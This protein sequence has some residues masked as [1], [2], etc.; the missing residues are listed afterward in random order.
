MGMSLL[1][2][3]GNIFPG[4][5][6]GHDIM[7]KKSLI[8][9][10]AAFV[11]VLW[12]TFAVIYGLFPWMTH[13]FDPLTRMSQSL[14]ETGIDHSR[15]YYTDVEQVRESEQYLRGVLDQ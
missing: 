12:V 5:L 15:Y 3:A 4:F 14:N 10:L 2:Q 8:R 11:F 1:N 6:Q 13:S 9:R 7:A